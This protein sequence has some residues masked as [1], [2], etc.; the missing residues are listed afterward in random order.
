[1]AFKELDHLRAALR[2]SESPSSPAELPFVLVVDDDP[3][4]R[5]SLELI[6]SRLY[7]VQLAAS[8]HDGVAL[9]RDELSAVILDVKMS[10]IDG[11]TTYAQMRK[12]DADL[13]IIFH[14]AYQDIK[15][16]YE[17]LNECRPF[18]YITKGEDHSKLLRTVADAVAQRARMMSYRA[19]QSK[20]STVQT[21][22]ESLKKRLAGK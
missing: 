8:G 17:I 2:P 20:L 21:Q 13:P 6:L 7:R 16:P 18:G 10:G 11:F 14:S 19:L 12:L 5:A 15:D 22:M 9:V 4:M 1:M 3:H